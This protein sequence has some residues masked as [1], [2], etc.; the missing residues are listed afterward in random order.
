MGSHQLDYAIQLRP[1]FRSHSR[2]VDIVDPCEYHSCN[3]YKQRRAALVAEVGRVIPRVTRLLPT[4]L[5]II[6]NHSYAGSDILNITAGH[7]TL[8]FH[9][10]QLMQSIVI[11]NLIEASTSTTI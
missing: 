8:A 2:L 3:L 11:G 10:H 5:K 1:H 9:G 7:D 6:V 4:F